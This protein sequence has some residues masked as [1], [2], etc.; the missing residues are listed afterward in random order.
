MPLPFKEPSGTLL[1]LM[2]VVVQ[3]GQRF[4]SIADMQVGDGNQGA[5]VGTTV[6]L[7]ERGSRVMSA[8]HK[9]LYQ[10]MK[11]EF[12]LIADNF[13]TFL[14]K[15]Y[16]Y[17]VVGG[18]RQVFAADFDQRVDIIP[19]ADPNIFSQ[20]QRISLAQTELQIAMSNPDLHN[21]YQAY[22]HMY[23]ALGVKDIDIL[24]PPPAPMQPMDPASENI[25]ALNNKKFQAFA[26]QDHQAHMK[27]HIQFMGTIMVRNNPK[28]LARLQQNCMEHINLMAQEQIQLEFAQEMQQM[29]QMQLQMQ[30]IAQQAGPA[31]LQNPQFMQ[32][33]RQIQATQR[34]MEARKSQLIAEFTED[35]V[36]AE[37]Q[38]LNQV[39]N[40]P[41]LKLKD[42]DLDLKA[43]EA[44]R[45]EEEGQQKANLDMMRLMQN[46]DIA[47][48]K[49][50]QNDKHA[51]L[52]ASVSLAKQGIDE[53]QAV[54]KETN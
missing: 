34:S 49:L 32:M 15:V 46:K 13:A 42:R 31:V 27:A 24:L 22:R 33:Q 54:V 6:A 17:D 30:A 41:V 40:D 53:M 52:R 39:E 51:K 10:S 5:A 29:Q 7:L 44:Q 11:R 14:P 45:K 4:A 20:T 50:D 1:Q 26:G 2:G 38:V 19:V 47:E 21:I 48:E 36:K 28:A 3:A 12:M 23:E 37:K 9:R 43:R 25:M 16:P 35:Y 18:Q 8:I